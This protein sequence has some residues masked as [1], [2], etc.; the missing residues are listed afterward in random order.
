MV[1][2]TERPRTRCARINA[3][4]TV[5][6]R[7][8]DHVAI[9][10][11]KIRELQ[12]QWKCLQW[13]HLSLQSR[14]RNL[15]I[16]YYA[17]EHDCSGSKPTPEVKDKAKRTLRLL[18]RVKPCATPP[19][20][21]PHLLAARRLLAPYLASIQPIAEA[22]AR[23][24]KEIRM[25]VRGL[26]CTEWVQS[27]P[28][29]NFDTL[30]A[31]VGIVG[32]LS[33]FPTPGKLKVMASIGFVDGER[34]RRVKGNPVKAKR[35]RFSPLR[36]GVLSAMANG[37]QMGRLEPWRTI[38]EERKKKEEV[39]RPD[40]S[41]IHRHDSALR[42]VACKMLV[43]LWSQWR[44]ERGMYHWAEDYLKTEEVD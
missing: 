40:I 18:L 33:R 3:T 11:D 27:T 30:A 41:K 4:P 12:H 9:L 43:A 10:C 32:D 8:D 44:R 37:A 24:K 22:Q 20:L 28:G 16:R 42:V 29:F 13:T 31:V 23:M 19:D 1:V 39:T 6:P 36:R 35:M 2:E 21:A 38:Y 5:V 25:E 34:Q 15:L 7:P 14:C 17:A 26:P